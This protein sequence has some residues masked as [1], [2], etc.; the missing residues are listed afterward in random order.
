[1][2]DHPDHV[3]RLLARLRAALP[4]RARV[5]P[6]LAATLQ[7]KNTVAEI[8]STCSIT[9]IS[10]ARDEDGIMCRL[11]FAREIETTAFASI[12][13]LRFDVRLPLAHNIAAY[14][15][16]RVRLLPRQPS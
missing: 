8:P 12:T 2:I 3:K 15:K 9:W 1:M 16:R 14:Q 6:E 10:Y 11:D 13:H 4:L 5:T 7:A